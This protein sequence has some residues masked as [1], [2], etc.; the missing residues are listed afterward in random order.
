MLSVGTSV[1]F[2]MCS[3]REASHSMPCNRVRA[4]RLQQLCKQLGV[5]AIL[6]VA[7]WDSCYNVSCLQLLL[8]LCDERT[9]MQ[10]LDFAELDPLLEEAVF[11]ITPSSVQFYIPEES[12]A[13]NASLDAQGAPD[14]MQ[15]S[16]RQASPVPEGP[17]E[18]PDPKLTAALNML[19]NTSK[20]GIPLGTEIVG[21]AGRLVDPC[22]TLRWPFFQGLA[23]LASCHMDT[24]CHSNN[25]VGSC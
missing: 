6:L 10:T 24:D 14:D 20:L 22:E 25:Q 12:S 19:K 23:H 5:D 11:V 9:G 3:H 1:G 13:D 15:A 4:Q 8:W 16:P 17:D 21:G 7:G 18:L 2:E